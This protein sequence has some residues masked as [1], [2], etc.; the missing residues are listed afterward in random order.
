M[1]TTDIQIVMYRSALC[2]FA[3]NIKLIAK[4]NC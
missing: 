3:I 4:S 1:L 2:N